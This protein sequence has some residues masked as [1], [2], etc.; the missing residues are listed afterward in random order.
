MR[1]LANRLFEGS[2]DGLPIHV[3]TGW[4]EEA[5][6][7]AGDWNLYLEQQTGIRGDRWPS[8]KAY[9]L[10]DE[11]QESYWD[12]ALWTIFFKSIDP[13]PYCPFV[14]LF[15]SYGSPGRGNMGFDQKKHVKTPMTFD[16]EQIISMRPVKFEYG[17]ANSI[18]LLLEENEAF[19]LM[20]RYTSIFNY[21]HLH[22]S[23]DLR[24]ELFW[25]SD[26]HI[27]CLTGLLIVLGRVPV[28]P[29]RLLLARTNVH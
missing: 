5:V 12:Q 22:P 26:G 8:N 29:P 27:G 25:I 28:G 23:A 20:D 18:G 2:A 10:F 21:H 9:L 17:P 16:A 7:E 6:K 14:V 4:E 3:I 15:T 24:R 19:D 1:L 13:L 11:A